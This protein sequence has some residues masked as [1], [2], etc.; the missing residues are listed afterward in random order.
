MEGTK[1]PD[2]GTGSLVSA[3]LAI[4]EMLAPQEDNAE[5]SS[6]A[7]DI[8]SEDLESTGEA[9]DDAEIEEA[10]EDFDSEEDDVDL[11]DDEDELEQ[12]AGDANTFTVKVAGKEVEV[13]LDELKSG[14]SRQSDYTKKA[15]AL[16]DERKNFEQDRD[17]VLLER[18]QYSQ[19]LGALQQ[20]LV[21]LND[22][23]QILTG[24]MTKTPSRRRA[25]SG[26]TKN[27]TQSARQNCRRLH[28]SS[29][30]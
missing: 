17:S 1:T 3:Q 29:S 7:T 6:E 10:D 11:A 5:V 25:R 23:P 4:A 19:L 18:Q 21:S 22:R 26:C 15:Q 14:Y 2:M 8:E 24:S 30:G 13:D 9:Y 28:K 12:E 16:A 27:E 20:Q